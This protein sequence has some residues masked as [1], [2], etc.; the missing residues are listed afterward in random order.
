M[1]SFNQVAPAFA[2]RDFE[3]MVAFYCDVLG[4]EV[5]YKTGVYAALARD[6]VQL[7]IYPER[8][9]TVGGNNSAYFFVDGVDAIYEAVRERATII[10]PISDQ[11][12]GLRDFLMA[13]PEGNMI[14]IAQRK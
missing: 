8:D 7:H 6:G 12:Y 14:G 5:G 9:G 13:D 3:G 10:H 1:P 2:A 11:D 4:F